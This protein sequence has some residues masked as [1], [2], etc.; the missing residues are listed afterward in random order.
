[1][2]N[3]HL[4]FRQFENYLERAH[5]HFY[6]KEYGLAIDAFNQALA[7]NAC[8]VVALNMRGCAYFILEK[9]HLAFD[10]F[11]KAIKLDPK[12]PAVYINRGNVY[13]ELGNLECAMQDYYQALKV[14]PHRQDALDNIKCIGDLLKKQEVSHQPFMIAAGPKVAETEDYYVGVPVFYADILDKNIT[15]NDKQNEML[16]SGM[17]AYDD[18]N[19]DLALERFLAVLGKDANN[20]KAHCYIGSV[21]S[22]KNEFRL[23]VIHSNK[24]IQLNPDLAMSYFNRGAAYFVGGLNE[25]AMQDLMTF[26]EKNQ[27]TKNSDFTEVLTKLGILFLNKSSD[28]LPNEFVSAFKAGDIRH[29]EESS[30]LEAAIFCFEKA[31]QLS[32]NEE[33]KNLIFQLYEE[34]KIKLN[35]NG[36]GVQS[37]QLE[38]MDVE[39]NQR[40]KSNQRFLE[41]KSAMQA[42]QKFFNYIWHAEEPE[43]YVWDSGLR[44]NKK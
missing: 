23:A 19:Y 17:T 9:Y 38:K 8:N 43:K 42:K 15:E 27:D 29:D 14:D 26:L 33:N 30:H 28:Y 13:V 24:A 16:S 3:Y 35:Q 1:M 11:S 34:V 10:D 41:S 37:L 22:K 40:H 44:K 21:Y 4:L 12:N 2:Q 7:I 31:Y 25:L 6:Q 32:Q 20:A 39:N 5:N 36:I 18:Q